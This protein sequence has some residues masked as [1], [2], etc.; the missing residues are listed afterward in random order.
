MRQKLN[1]TSFLLLLLATTSYGQMHNYDYQIKLANITDT[2]HSITLPNTVFL[3]TLES[4]SDIRI[5]GITAKNDTIEAPYILN[6]TAPQLQTKTIEYQLI[7][8]SSKDGVSFFSLKI[9]SK[10]AVNHINLDF[11]EDNFDWRVLLQGSHNQKDWF[12]IYNDYRIVAIKNS[13]TN[14]NFTDLTFSP[15]EYTYF[16]IGI[17]SDLEPT[18]KKATLEYQ[19]QTTANITDRK[20]KSFTTDNN[21]KTKQTI[22]HIALEKKAPTHQITI[23]VNDKIDYYRPIQI[24]E[25]VD[26]VK[27]EKGFKYNYKTLSYGTLTSIEK[28]TFTFKNTFAKN[29]RITIS[30]FDNEPL[31]ITGI[32]AKGYRFQLIA[33]FTTPATYY[34]TYGNKEAYAPSY[35]IAKLNLKMPDTISK[36]SLGESQKIIKNEKIAPQPL[37]KSEIWLWA[38]M[39]ILLLVIGWFS[40]KMLTKK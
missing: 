7:N 12:T 9:P 19:Q 39:G 1:K 27:T 11:E 14:Y 13:R 38:V 10:D 17:K 24:E 28:N 8:A 33:R 20:L 25:L 35:D 31:Q 18:L 40:Y 30:N 26:S 6:Y 2:W 36:L 23:K 4:L 16:R 15:V 3:N 37:F 32:N 22:V 29:L 21:K 5:Y 34:L